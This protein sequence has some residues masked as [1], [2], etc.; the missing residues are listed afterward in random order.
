MLWGWDGFLRVIRKKSPKMLNDFL[1]IC[2]SKER[3]DLR[4]INLGRV[5]IAVGKRVSVTLLYRARL[6]K[7]H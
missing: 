3:R 2:L 5:S 1:A 6:R 4:K 7:W